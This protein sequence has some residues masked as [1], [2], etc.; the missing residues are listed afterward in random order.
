MNVSSLSRRR[1]H[2]KLCKRLSASCWFRWLPYE[3]GRHSHIED[4]CIGL[5]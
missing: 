4:F 1:L 5:S 2:V 3:P